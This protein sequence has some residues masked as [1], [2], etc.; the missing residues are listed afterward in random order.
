MNISR[1]TE[2]S[3]FCVPRDFRNNNY[4]KSFSELIFCIYFPQSQ[5]N[6]A[7]LLTIHGD[8]W[9]TN[10]CV[11]AKIP[12]T[13]AISSVGQSYRLITGWSKVRALDGPPNFKT[14]YGALAQLGARNTGSV[15]VR[16]SNPLCSTKK[17]AP[18]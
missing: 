18:L 8:L 7:N 15:E 3:F 17:Q 14:S 16:G 13:R 6:F 2:M 12:H 9:Y 1:L 4:T 10:I 5:E 11:T